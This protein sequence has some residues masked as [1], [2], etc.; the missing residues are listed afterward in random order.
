MNNEFY[1]I[2]ESVMGMNEETLEPNAILSLGL[3][4]FNY[5]NEEV[6]MI[7][8][9]PIYEPIVQINQNEDYFIVLL[10]FKEKAD[11]NYQKV[12]EHFRKYFLIKQNDTEDI[13]TND[14]LTIFPAK[15]IN[16]LQITFSEPIYISTSAIKPYKK[17]EA[18][19]I[20]YK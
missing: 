6:K 14:V 19:K 3:N 9:I 10:K 1:E 20:L 17:E 13:I 15:K 18:I 7:E 2:I 5:K 8:N 12:L 16:E 11:E 4:Q